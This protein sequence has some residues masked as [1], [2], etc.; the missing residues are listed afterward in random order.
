MPDPLTLSVIGATGLQEGIKFLYAQAS[1]LLQRRRDRK[2]VAGDAPAVELRLPV[3]L[4]GG[5]IEANPDF[6][7]VAQNQARLTELR[8]RLVNV[9]DDLVDVDASDT[10]LLH[11]VSELRDLLED[12]FGKYLTFTAETDRPPSGAPI[13]SGRVRAEELRNADATG[14]EVQEITGGTARGEVDVDVASEGSRVVGGRFGRIG[15][16]QRHEE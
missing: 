15:P 16:P 7:V 14:I 4:G 6:D 12:V 11:D 1:D 3:S 5:T 2:D 10:T 13:A 9:A 8:S